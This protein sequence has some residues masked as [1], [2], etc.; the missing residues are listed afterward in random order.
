MARKTQK[1]VTLVK[2]E[3]AIENTI[4]T[5]VLPEMPLSSV[6]QVREAIDTAEK[7]KKTKLS[8]AKKV[9]QEKKES[10]KPSVPEFQIASYIS[11]D[12]IKEI[13]F[14]QLI[15]LDSTPIANAKLAMREVQDGHVLSLMIGYQENSDSIPMIEVIDTSWGYAVINGY[16]RW[17]AMRRLLVANAEGQRIK[18]IFDTTTFDVLV[19]D[20]KTERD[21]LKAAFDANQT[22]GL[23]MSAGSKTRY[24]LW[25][26]ADAKERGEI[27]RVVDAARIARVDTHTVHMMA[28]RLARKEQELA[29]Q[30]KMVDQLVSTNEDVEKVHE[31][32]AE[33]E[34]KQA[35]KENKKFPN[36]CN[37]LF[38]SIREIV[39]TTDNSSHLCE[40]FI[41]R[42]YATVTQENDIEIM[43]ETLQKTL[44]LIKEMKLNQS[45]TNK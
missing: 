29:K 15:A 41:G 31:A 4:E 19:K 34:D 23:P 18:D 33:Y 6:Q 1:T 28:M 3:K 11:G 40:Y 9:A 14:S 37:N 21:V 35:T 17:E 12:Y 27:L 26:I 8:E 10:E 44:D 36:A 32:I 24:A 22:N 30:E 5:Q 45:G 2:P 43:I 16:H 25:L 20:L 39:D 42:G 38:K 7:A 13:T